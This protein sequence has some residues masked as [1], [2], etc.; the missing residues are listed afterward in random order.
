MP[1]WTNS[2]TLLREYIS[3]LSE[4][5]RLSTENESFNRYKHILFASLCAAYDKVEF[6]EEVSSNPLLEDPIKKGRE[7]IRSMA[8]LSGIGP[9][10]SGESILY[11]VERAK[12]IL[13]KGKKK[14]FIVLCDGLSL[15]EY[16]Y[17][18]NKFSKKISSDGLLYAINP[19]GMTKTYEYLT[20]IFLESPSGNIS[21]G[22]LG[23]ILKERFEA[24]GSRVFRTID[25][26]VHKSQVEKF[27]DIFS[28]ASSLYRTVENIAS[29]V[30]ILLEDYRVL[31]L[32]DHGYDVSSEE[33]TW[34][35]YH[36]FSSGKP[37]LSI[38]SAMLVIG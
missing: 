31:I 13:E 10:I 11:A 6:C 25:E 33:S 17:L 32:S 7:F 5:L 34:Y 38:F 24:A 2:L 1:E 29:E 22:I 36:K 3:N 37:C 15:P 35:L 18:Y 23:E 19:G 14:P 16:A 28:M 8:K 30:S 4:S 9:M 27:T 20:S 12:K 21:M 26:L